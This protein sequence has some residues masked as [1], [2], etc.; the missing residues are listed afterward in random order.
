MK[1]WQVLFELV[2]YHH[3]I[4]AAIYDTVKILIGIV[5]D[6]GSRASRAHP[7]IR[8]VHEVSERPTQQT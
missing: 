4:F 1:Y 7:E 2:M 3:E 5:M 8:L 6:D